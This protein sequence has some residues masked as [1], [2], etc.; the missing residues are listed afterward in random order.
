VLPAS[1]ASVP[2]PGDPEVLERLKKLFASLPPKWVIGGGR[3]PA[4]EISGLTA[5][6]KSGPNTISLGTDGI[7][8]KTQAGGMSFSASIGQQNWTM[9]FTI[10]RKAPKMSDYETVFKNGEAAI[11]GV[12]ANLNKVD[13]KDPGKTK[14]TFSPYLTPITAAIDAASSTAAMRPG[15]ISFGAWLQGGG[16]GGVPTAPSTGGVMLTIVF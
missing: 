8:L 15:D 13:F 1:G 7:E 11:R 2:A 3:G 6:L 5:K 10:G 12:L 14:T 4:I 9:T 16:Q